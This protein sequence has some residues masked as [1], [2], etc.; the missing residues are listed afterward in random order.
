MKRCK[1]EA[2]PVKKKN[3]NNDLTEGPIGSTLFFFALPV[4]FGN[5]LQSLNGTVSSIW[6]GKFLGEVAFAATSN[7][8]MIMFFLISA[9]FGIGMAA[10]IMVG[11][12]MGAKDISQAKKVVGTSAVFFTCLS[13]VIALVG[14]ICSRQFLIWMRTPEESIEM[15]VPYL[16]IIFLTIPFMYFYQYIMMI[17][18]GSGDAKTP[19]YFL[20]L[21]TVLNSIL[22]PPLIFGF[23]PIPAMGVSGSAL[24]G[25]AANFISLIAL[26][27]YLYRS[28]YELRIT[29]K[30]MHYLRLDF[31]II[32]VLV[33]KGIPMGLNMII[34]SASGIALINL[35][36]SYGPIAT[37]AFGATMQLSNYVQMPAMAIGAAVSSIAAQNVGAGKWDRVHRTT[38][39]GILFNIVMTGF[40]VGIIYA[41]DRQALGL[42]LQDEEAMRIGITANAISL[43]GFIL[44]G[45]TFVIAGVV[46]ANGAVMVPLLITFT[47]LWL[48]RIPLAYYWG[49]RFGLD[50]LWWSF[51]AG[52]LFGTAATSVYYLRGSWKKATMLDLPG[53]KENPAPT[54]GEPV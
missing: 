48:V 50:A 1:G 22:N 13:L 8:N 27:Y 10:T 3:L 12:S 49:G 23:G 53:K 40:L 42:F 20:L 15:A 44:F 33:K 52:F 6:V 5:L 18:R 7:A 37:A 34:V 24:A 2:C 26:M 11:Q 39:A 35:V 46:R 41:F 29:R 25:V 43:W 28:Q 47:A 45:I 31:S 32:G 51:P 30:D 19:F 17:L 9:I 36:N 14:I 4:L 16:Q 38:L 54:T 21:S